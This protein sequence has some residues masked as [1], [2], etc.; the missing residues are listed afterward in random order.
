MSNFFVLE[1]QNLFKWQTLIIWKHY[2]CVLKAVQTF[3]LLFRISKQVG[4][5]AVVGLLGKELVLLQSLFI[6]DQLSTTKKW[7][8]CI[9]CIPKIFSTLKEIALFKKDVFP[10]SDSNENKKNLKNIR[11]F[12]MQIKHVKSYVE[13]IIAQEQ[14][15]KPDKKLQM[16]YQEVWIHLPSLQNSTTAVEEKIFTENQD[17]LLGINSFL[18]SLHFIRWEIKCIFPAY[19]DLIFSTDFFA[20]V[21]YFVVVTYFITWPKMRHFL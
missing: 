15:L 4:D 3:P 13:R 17:V 1:K 18:L 20:L 10:H 14:T 16:F 19:K 11:V 2:F 12:L 8:R 5:G 21:N 9:F 6:P 7:N